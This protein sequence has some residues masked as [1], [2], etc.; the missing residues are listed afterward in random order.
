[1]NDLDK[2]ANKINAQVRGFYLEGDV[3]VKAIRYLR[4][5]NKVLFVRLDT[6]DE[7]F[8]EYKGSAL[9]RKRIFTI[10]E[11]AKLVGRKAGTVRE[12]ERTGLLPPASRFEYKG[13][14]YRYYNYSDVR[15]LE[16]FFSSRKV[17]RPAKSIVH[18]ASALKKRIREAKKGIR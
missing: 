14:S 18:S 13:V 10:G 7:Y 12:Y 15:D 2:F 8:D 9:F 5:E 17:G 3:V 4:R 11:V 16:S 1:V 6:G